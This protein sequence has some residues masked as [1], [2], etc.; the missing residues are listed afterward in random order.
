MN[1]IID[2]KKPELMAPAGDWT[3]LRTAVKSGAN[4]V[5]FGIDQLNMR[6]KAKNFQ[7]ENLTEI[8]EYC[9]SQNV[10][11]YLTVNTIIYENEIKQVEEIISTAKSS[12]IDLIICWDLSV[13][14]ICRKHQ[15]PFAVSTQASVSNS[16]SAKL[17]KELGAKRVVLARECLLEDIKKIKS[18]IDIEIEAFIHGAMC[19]AVS[20]R[21]FMSHEMFGKSANRG[22][23]IQP[24]RREYQVKDTQTGNEMI[25]GEDYVMSPKDL[26][27]I[28]HIDKL[29]EV[30]IDS[31]KIEGRKRSPEYVSTVVKAYRKAID[32]YFEGKLTKE[33]KKELL[34]ELSKVYN[35]GFSSGFYFKAPSTEEY[36][37]GY[38][39]QA[40]V[41]KTYIGKVL[42]YFKNQKIGFAK[43][44]TGSISLNDK[45]YIIGETTGVVELNIDSI[46]SNDKNVSQAKKGD[47]ITFPC[48]ELIRPRDKVYKIVSK[49]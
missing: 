41:K 22:E 13:I 45:V 16:L 1:K 4:A 17:Y 6:A 18:E 8:V 15:I 32:L 37:D 48:S 5:Y 40:E 11:T 38:G 27:M 3:M 29:I 19:I 43:L 25:L 34:K 30:G 24:C 7:I 28:E 47:E 44:E 39:N 23:C 42:N 20:G 14:N 35:R 2:I 33:I 12:G 9:K 31:F 10:K 21:C 36:T 46:F 26:C 49:N